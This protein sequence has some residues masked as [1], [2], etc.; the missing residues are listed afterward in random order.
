MINFK[1]YTYNL[2]FY[3]YSYL[4]SK[5]AFAAKAFDDFPRNDPQTLS[6]VWIHQQL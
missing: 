6:D 2:K 1:F 5:K 3:T 4:Y